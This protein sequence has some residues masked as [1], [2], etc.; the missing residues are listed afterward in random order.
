MLDQGELRKHFATAEQNSETGLIYGVPLCALAEGGPSVVTDNGVV[1]SMTVTE[2]M[3]LMTEIRAPSPIRTGIDM[4]VA[5][6]ALLTA[7]KVVTTVV[8]APGKLN[9]RWRWGSVS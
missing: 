6:F 7:R 4:R 8:P 3:V 1:A 2:L 5:C 9:R